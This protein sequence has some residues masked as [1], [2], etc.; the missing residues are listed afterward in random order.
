MNTIVIVSHKKGNNSQPKNDI[1]AQPECVTSNHPSIMT[2]VHNEKTA[3]EKMPKKIGCFDFLK[4]QGW[5][6]EYVSVDLLLKHLR[7]KC[8]SEGSRKAYL[9]RLHLFCLSVGRNPDEIITWSKHEIEETVQR[10][11][12]FYNN[13][14]HSARYT[15]NVLALLKTFFVVNGFKGSRQLDVEGYYMPTRY[16]KLAEY[17][18]SKPEIYVMVDSACSLRDRAII[19][20][21]YSSGFRNSTLRALLIK[22]IAQELLEGHDNLLLPCYPEMKLIDPGACKG[23]IPYFTFTSDEA[24]QAIKLYLRER[25]EKYGKL[26]GEA[27]LFASEFNQ[28]NKEERELK[29]LGSRQLQW[30]VKSCAKRAALPQ[31]YSVK[32]HCIRKASETVYHSELVGGGLLDQKTQEF[33]LG[34]IL[35]G[36][37]DTYFDKSKK[38]SLRSQF[39][40]LNFGRVVVENKFK[41]LKQ[42]LD[43]AFAN[44][45]IDPDEVVAEYVKMRNLGF[46][47]K[48]EIT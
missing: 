33:F 30:I 47:E 19:L 40:K 36:S 5:Q 4:V 22:D 48:L 9:S 13:E 34:H 31:W 35:P 26:L 42:A 41:V 17:I 37:Q 6:S 14:N 12:D 29:V 1:C 15:N 44:S 20:T 38:E 7:R 10:Y 23:N 18:P 39:A 28:I 2:S 32:P 43:K 27:P 25:K 8:G 46:G 3:G 21:L 16:Q 11:A 24:T 45:G